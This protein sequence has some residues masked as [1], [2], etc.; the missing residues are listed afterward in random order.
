MDPL[1]LSHILLVLIASVA[2]AFFQYFYQG[3]KQSRVTI[4]LFFLRSLTL[5]FIGVLLINPQ[6]EVVDTK[7]HKPLISLLIDNSKSMAFFKEE[8]KIESI[9]ESIKKNKDLNNKFEVI[10]FSF[11]E[12][13]QLSDSLSFDER[14]TD[15][16]EAMLSIDKLYPNKK[17]ATILITDG[18][19]TSGNDYEFYKPKTKIFPIIIGDTTLHQDIQ[20]SNLNVNKYSY[21][22]NNFPVEAMILYEGDSSITANFMITHKGKKVISKKLFF[23]PKNKTN[24]ISVELK[25]KEKGVQYYQASIKSSIEEKN[26]KNN[27][28]D[29]S[30]EVI[31]EQT[32]ILLLSSII[33]PDLGAIKKAVESNKQRKVEIKIMNKDAFD[34]ENYQMFIFY[35][36]NFSFRDVLNQVNSNYFLISGIKTDWRFINNLELGIKKSTINQNE[37]SAPV[38]NSNFLTFM[39]ENIG[40]EEFPPLEDKFGK[41]QFT[42]KNQALLGQNIGGIPSGQPL[43]VA[44]EE[45]EKKT[46]VLFGEGIWKWRSSSYLKEKSFEEFDKFLNNIIQYLASNK[47]RNRLEITAKKSYSANEDIVFSAFYVDQNYRFDKRASLDLKIINSSTKE[48]ISYPFSL[49]NNSYRVSIEGLEPGIYSY[50][51]TV[52]G[53]SITNRGS[54]RVTA[55]EIEEQ[56]V[57]ANQNKLK[58]I[59]LN[60]NGKVYYSNQ[61]AAL[62][63]NLNSD[64]N[65]SKVQESII[66]QK[67]LIEWKWY[68]IL[69]V[70]SLA[71]EWFIRKYFGRI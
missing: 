44:L 30:V 22:N 18:N 64:P 69:I 60:T 14:K 54:F 38:Y 68:L 41:I 50:Q 42:R 57:N 59:A 32:K 8:K 9:V 70:I 67:S 4:V 52:K 24:T 39:Q 71:S 25:S 45:N 21:L 7:N 5:F 28:R 34:I 23:S 61:I 3:K 62:L 15:I 35:Q 63:N 48:E 53:Q 27:S 55:F 40:F 19:Q 51:V 17:R 31:D 36:P 13:V 26:I 2:I 58:K 10:S 11:G 65:Y 16:N 29:F 37:A 49:M 56:F 33:H 43:L 20:I 6:I 47:K 1:T 46:M 66:S 12:D